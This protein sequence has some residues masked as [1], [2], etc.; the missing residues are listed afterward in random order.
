MYINYDSEATGLLRM[1][2]LITA[3]VS[4]PPMFGAIHWAVAIGPSYND[5]GRSGDKDLG[6][7]DDAR[8]E[9]LEPKS[10]HRT[11]IFVWQILT[12]VTRAA[13]LGLL[14]FV[15]YEHWLEVGW[16]EIRLAVIETLPHLFLLLLGNVALHLV[17]HCGSV[18]GGIL[19]A[20]V[21][22]GFFRVNCTFT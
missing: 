14:A 6:G 7:L 21:P 11:Y 16:F 15:Y 3:I 2:P 9:E 18:M 17:Y 22:N 4:I 12:F 20:F 13:S 1:M 19:G 5:T 10:R 8:S